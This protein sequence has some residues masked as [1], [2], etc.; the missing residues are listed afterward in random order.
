MKVSTVGR[1]R[2]VSTAISVGPHRFNQFQCVVTSRCPTSRRCIILNLLCCFIHEMFLS[3][4]C[5]NKRFELNWRLSPCHRQGQWGLLQQLPL[6]SVPRELDSFD[7]FWQD[8]QLGLHFVWNVG[9]YRIA[10]AQLWCL[11]CFPWVVDRVAQRSVWY[12]DYNRVG[13]WA[14]GGR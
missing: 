14:A 10:N 4:C 3:C 8:L 13:G 1:L 12:R 5:V 9:L 6:Q 11:N 7:S 2:Y